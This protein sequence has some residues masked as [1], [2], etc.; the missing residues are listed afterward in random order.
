MSDVE[1]DEKL[2]HL[3]KEI[4]SEKENKIIVLV[5]TKRIC[6]E[7]TTKMRREGGGPWVSM[8]T[9]VNRSVCGFLMNSN[10]EKLLF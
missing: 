5:E 1:M 7:L 2:F 8:V 10:M 9:R 4:M 3:M 6:Y